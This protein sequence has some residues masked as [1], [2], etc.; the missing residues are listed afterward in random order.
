[1]LRAHIHDIGLGWVFVC[2]QILH[3]L[4]LLHQFIK[5]SNFIH[6]IV[7]DPDFS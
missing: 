2:L 7:S 3:F 6:V 5:I 4:L 1:M